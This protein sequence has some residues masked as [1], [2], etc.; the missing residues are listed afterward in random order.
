M[1]LHVVDSPNLGQILMVGL[2][3][4]QALAEFPG[5]LGLGTPRSALV[6]SHTSS[7]R[8]MVEAMSGPDEK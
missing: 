2:Q 7:R 4:F 5:G 1:R 3:A 8:V 6:V